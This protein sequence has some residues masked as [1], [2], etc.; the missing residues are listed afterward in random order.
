M[1]V[2]A[3]IDGYSFPLGDEARRCE[4]D[5]TARQHY[6]VTLSLLLGYKPITD[7]TRAQ[8]WVD[9]LGLDGTT[10]YLRAGLRRLLPAV[11]LQQEGVDGDMLGATGLG[12]ALCARKCTIDDV[13]LAV[14]A[15][16]RSE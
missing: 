12:E 2:H 14:S 3:V 16:L 1:V 9:L 13:L 4:T 6:V 15:L 11:A 8:L 7:H 5:P 10:R